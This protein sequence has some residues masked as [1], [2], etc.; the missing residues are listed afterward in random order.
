MESAS[1]RIA[2][3]IV[4]FPFSRRQIAR[5]TNAAI[6][7]SGSA[8]NRKTG[9][10][11]CIPS[12]ADRNAIHDCAMLPLRGGNLPRRRRRSAHGCG[13]WRGRMIDGRRR[14]SAHDRGRWRGRTAE[15]WI[16]LTRRLPQRW[17]QG[18]DWA[19]GFP[20]RRT[21]AGR[22][23]SRG[24]VKRRRANRRF[25]MLA[26]AA[27][28]RP[29]CGRQGQRIRRRVQRRGGIGCGP[30]RRNLS[31]WRLPRQALAERL[32]TQR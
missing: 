1:H 32:R 11:A 28:L 4:L 26:L 10:S 14:G 6:S 17:R 27:R 31:L 20:R 24:A 22:D 16:L 7:A 3:S 5:R 13:R 18:L 29:S 9:R 19:D 12:L 8:P 30:L 2:S 15:R 23:S 21:D 25:A